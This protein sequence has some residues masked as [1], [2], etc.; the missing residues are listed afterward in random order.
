[1][2]LLTEIRA[3]LV[4]EFFVELF[5]SFSSPCE[6]TCRY[7]VTYYLFNVFKINLEEEIFLDSTSYGSHECFILATEEKEMKKKQSTKRQMP[8]THKKNDFKYN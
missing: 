7:T 3:K 6:E 4:L 5:L 8:C 2:A 1:M